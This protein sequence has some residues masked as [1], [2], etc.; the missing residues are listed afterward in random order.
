MIETF[1][2]KFREDLT[3]TCRVD[4]DAFVPGML[5]H[6]EFEW[7]S[8]PDLSIF[9]AYR[10]WMHVVNQRTVEALKAEMLYVFLPSKGVPGSA[11]FYKHGEE[12]VLKS[13]CEAI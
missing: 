12:P 1:I 2:H 7:S 6:L 13:S 10:E 4:F 11:W 5:R 8:K 3:C 9:P